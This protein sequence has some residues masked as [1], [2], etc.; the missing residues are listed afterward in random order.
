LVSWNRSVLVSLWLVTIAIANYLGGVIGFSQG[1]STCVT[2]TGT[3]AMI[4][5]TM[6]RQLRDGNQDEVIG[7]LETRLDSQVSANVFGE[8]SYYSPYNLRLRLLFGDNPVDSNAW[9]LSEVLRYREQYPSPS[10]DTVS[11]RLIEAL[12]EYRDVPRPDY[13][14]PR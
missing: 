5:A 4:T 10:E 14:T 7:Y 6:L 1:H 8:S 12:E 11:T 3:E 13:S 9:G 2:L